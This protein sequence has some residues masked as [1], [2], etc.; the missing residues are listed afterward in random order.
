MEVTMRKS[1]FIL[2]AIIIVLFI[3][4]GYFYSSDAESA[5][6]A[7]SAQSAL[8]AEQIVLI[9]LATPDQKPIT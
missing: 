6:Q 4:F 1:H 9:Q 3:V 2:T 5:Q 8:P 7:T